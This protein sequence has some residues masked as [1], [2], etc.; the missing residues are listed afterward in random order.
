MEDG[1]IYQKK[2]KKG[3]RH[4]FERKHKDRDP[5]IINITCD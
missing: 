1:V 5:N 4:R 3:R 2:K